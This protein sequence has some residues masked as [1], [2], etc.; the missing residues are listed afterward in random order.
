MDSDAS[1]RLAVTWS[2]GQNLAN[3]VG[4]PSARIIYLGRIY[5][6]PQ[7]PQLG[8]AHVPASPGKFAFPMA[9]LQQLLFAPLQH[10]PSLHLPTSSCFLF[11]L[12][13]SSRETRSCC[14]TLFPSPFLFLF[15]SLPFLFSFTLSLLFFLFSPFYIE[16][17]TK[18]TFQ[19]STSAIIT[20][21]KF[22]VHVMCTVDF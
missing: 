1:D 11:A 20:V 16:K 3:T 6:R 10:H 15:P 12:S 19:N 8:L 17:L 18:D 14:L 7:R 13:S 9:V 2:L 22:I 21:K 4:R 5:L